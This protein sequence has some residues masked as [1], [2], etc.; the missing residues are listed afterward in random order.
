MLSKSRHVRRHADTKVY[1]KDRKVCTVNDA[2]ILTWTLYES[3]DTLTI[4]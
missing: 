1:T 3:I 4:A 2:D